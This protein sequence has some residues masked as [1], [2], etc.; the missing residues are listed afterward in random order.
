M[1]EFNA[2]IYIFGPWEIFVVIN[3]I[4][5]YAVGFCALEDYNSDQNICATETRFDYC[6]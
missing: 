6:Y 4:L 5:V 1:V 2:V 3:F